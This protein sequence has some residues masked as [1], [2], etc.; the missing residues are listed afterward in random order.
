MHIKRLTFMNG[1][2]PM[3]TILKGL[4]AKDT[5]ILTR[6]LYVPVIA[7]NAL[8]YYYDENSN[9]YLQFSKVLA[10]PNML[11]TY[12]FLSLDLMGTI[13]LLAEETGY[14][15]SY[16]EYKGIILDMISGKADKYVYGRHDIYN[17]IVLPLAREKGFDALI[18][19]SPVPMPIY[20]LSEEDDKFKIYRLEG[21]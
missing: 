10:S 13:N 16:L 8:D 1:R 6:L 3:P 12:H 14:Q 18:L 2:L 15:L 9:L 17:D 4:H 7:D 5:I 20:D 19:T 11:T 21:H